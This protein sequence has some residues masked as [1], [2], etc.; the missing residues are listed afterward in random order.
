MIFCPFVVEKALT[1]F[2]LTLA[3]QVWLVALLYLFTCVHGPSYDLKM[4]YLSKRLMS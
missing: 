2:S 1:R 3:M 4:K